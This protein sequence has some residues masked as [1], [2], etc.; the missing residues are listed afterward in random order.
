M[1]DTSLKEVRHINNLYYTFFIM[2]LLVSNTLSPVG[3]CSSNCLI[4]KSYVTKVHDSKFPTVTYRNHGR[5]LFWK[6]LA[7]L[8]KKNVGLV[9]QMTNWPLLHDCYCLTTNILCLSS[10][11]LN[12]TTPTI[13]FL[14]NFLSSKLFY[15]SLSVIS[16]NKLSDE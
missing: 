11:G 9:G 6:S 4:Y 1:I 12:R 8:A 10:N 16:G 13:P 5:P 7:K 3:L 2:V 14:H 15:L